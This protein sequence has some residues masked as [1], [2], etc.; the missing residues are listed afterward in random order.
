MTLLY[1]HTL[2]GLIEEYT[3]ESTISSGLLLC[4]L[5]SESGT[6]K[7]KEGEKSKSE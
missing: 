7:N 6:C 5:G 1:V 2:F 3:R 4:R